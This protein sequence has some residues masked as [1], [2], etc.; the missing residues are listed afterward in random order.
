MVILRGIEVSELLLNYYIIIMKLGS[1]RGHDFNCSQ[2]DA[3]ALWPRSEHSALI[4]R[5]HRGDFWSQG[6]KRYPQFPS[7]MNILYLTVIAVIFGRILMCVWQFFRPTA[8]V[9]GRI[10]SY[11]CHQPSSAAAGNDVISWPTLTLQL[12]TSE[13]PMV[14]SSNST[15]ALYGFCDPINN[16]FRVCKL[17]SWVDCFL[18]KDLYAIMRTVWMDV[19][20]TCR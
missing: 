10:A 5:T 7:Q 20:M 15:C 14:S 19:P 9:L 16:D 18:S 6:C 11:S 12:C 4:I 2:E 1:N 8:G 13:P 17:W 3:L